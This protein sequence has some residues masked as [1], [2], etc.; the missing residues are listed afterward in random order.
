MQK[1]MLNIILTGF[2]GR[3][4]SNSQQDAVTDLHQVSEMIAIPLE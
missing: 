3:L 1:A 2:K 4:K